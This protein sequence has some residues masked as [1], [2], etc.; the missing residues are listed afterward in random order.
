[1][2]PASVNFNNA[3]IA[4]NNLIKRYS[5]KR[6]FNKKPKYNVSTLVRVSR[7]P[8]VF[9]KGYES[10]WTLEIF[11]IK[12]VSCTRQPPV[13]TL[14]DLDGEVIDGV[15]YEEELC[16]VE[17]NLS[18]AAFEIDKI[19]QTKGRGRTKKH[20]VSWCGYPAKFNTWILASELVDI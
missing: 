9:R 13:Y 5:I 17:K 2:T 11:R 6:K 16:P 4:R 12:H 1:M 18:E 8:E 7:A 20:L 15:Y 14:E 10:G 19:L 3:S